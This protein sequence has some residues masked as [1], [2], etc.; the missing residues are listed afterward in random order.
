[1]PH[2]AP[3]RLFLDFQAAVAGRY[4]LERE[5]G[6]GG[7]GVVYLARE[8]R[9]DRP[10]AI[11]LLPPSKASDPKLRERFLREARTA[12]KLSHP[13]IIPIH[14]VEEIGEFVFF[15]MAYVEGETL[16]DRVRNRG[17][18][19]PSEASRVLRDVAWALAY[20]HGQ[21]VVHRDV[22][23]DNILLENGGRVLVAD[24]G[25]ARAGAGAGALT[26]GGVGGAP[27]IMSSQP[28]PGEPV[29]ARSEP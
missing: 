3:D 10:V 28:G 22:K 19:A 20:A 17:P 27:G 13:N 24:F 6:R 18:M 23:P 9:L 5:L 11:K 2:L 4:S 25:I 16:T 7:M 14:A 26:T 21:G 1:M 29:R 12:A 15:A 8:V